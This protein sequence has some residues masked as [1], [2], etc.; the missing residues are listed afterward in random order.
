[1]LCSFGFLAPTKLNDRLISCF[2]ASA[3]A[4]DPRVYLIFVGENPGAQYGQ[5]LSETISKSGINDRIRITGWVGA[6]TYRN[7]LRAADMAIQLRALSR[8]KLQVV[9]WIA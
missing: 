8:E 6:E 2:L 9:C 7:Y 5:E 3:L 4:E 1:M